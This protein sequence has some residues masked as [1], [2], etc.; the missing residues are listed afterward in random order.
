MDIGQLFP[1]SKVLSIYLCLVSKEEAKEGK[2]W[3]FSQKL[4]GFSNFFL[5]HFCTCVKTTE[6]VRVL[7]KFYLPYL[8]SLQA[9]C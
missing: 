3:T 1:S 6:G 7:P 8:G 2:V 9:M 5:G 4:S